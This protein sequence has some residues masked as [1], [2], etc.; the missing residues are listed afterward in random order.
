MGQKQMTMPDHTITHG[1]ESPIEASGVVW[2]VDVPPCDGRSG[3]SWRHFDLVN[4]RTRAGIDSDAGWPAATRRILTGQDETPRVIDYDCVVCGVL[5]SFAR[6]GG[7]DEHDVIYWRFAATPDQMITSRRHPARSLAAGYHVTTGNSPPRNSAALMFFCL[8]DFARAAR[9]RL[10]N[11][12]DELDVIE[13]RLLDGRSSGMNAATASLLGQV[14]REAVILKRALTPVSRALDESEE[15]LPAWIHGPELD[16]A[17]SMVVDVLDDIAALNDRARSLQDDL[18]SRLA[19]GTN[20]RLYIV[21]L[22]T[23]LVMPATFVTGFFGMN[24]GGL[25]WGGDGSPMGTLLAGVTC[26]VA[27]LMMLLMLKRKRLL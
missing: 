16:T 23:T 15:E 17:Q 25:P 11:L 24:T 21:S 19:D 26:V 22:V 12:S 9:V 5:P 4:S 20:R 8:A 7:L 27:V 3:W 6:D 14:R 10:A 1:G 18:G 2:S 13:D